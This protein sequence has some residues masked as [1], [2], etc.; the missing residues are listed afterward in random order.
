MASS[1]AS[2]KASALRLILV[3]A[4]SEEQA[5][6]LARALVEE[7][8]AACVNLVAPLR[9]IYRWRGAIEDDR[10][11]LM[12]IKTRKALYARVE[13]RVRELHT[14]EVPEILSIALDAGH[15]PYLE[16]LFDSTAAVARRGARS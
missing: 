16:W 4:G 12:V 6:K 7:R 9:S 14:Y 2:R 8:L 3:T 15:Q 11:I 13:R 10:E 1:R 5:L